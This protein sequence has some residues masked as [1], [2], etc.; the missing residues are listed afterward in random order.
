M[1]INHY[2]LQRLAAIKIK[3]D[4]RKK[5]SP[6]RFGKDSSGNKDRPKGKSLVE[7][8]IQQNIAP[9]DDTEK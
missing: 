6:D 5:G 8:L 1:P 4:I 9:S 3:E 2:D 7:R